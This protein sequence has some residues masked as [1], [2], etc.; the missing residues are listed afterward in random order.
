MAETAST[1]ILTEA[2]G[3]ALIALNKLGSSIPTGADLNTFTAT[4]TNSCNTNTVFQSLVNA[5]KGAAIG[6]LQVETKDNGNVQQTWTNHN[7]V[8]RLQF[9]RTYAGSWSPWKSIQLGA[10]VVSNPYDYGAVGDG[11]ADDTA[12]LNSWLAAAG[13]VK[14]LGKTGVFRVVGGLTSTAADRTILSEGAKIVGDTENIVVLTVTGPNS[15]VRGLS[16]DGQSKVG[17][18]IIVRAPGCTIERNTVVNIGSRTVTSNL[19]VVGIGVTTTGGSLVR[20]N[21]IKNIYALGDGIVPGNGTG[22]SRA[23]AISGAD[24]PPALPATMITVVERNYI[25]GVAGEEGDAIAVGWIPS[26]ANDDI[27]PSARVVVRNN[28]IKNATKRFIKIQG[29]DCTVEKNKLFWDAGA[30]DP[31]FTSHITAY[32]GNNTVITGNETCPLATDRD[33]IHYD[34]GAHATGVVVTDNIIR[35][36]PD[37]TA[38]GVYVTLTDDAVISGNKL[39]G[40]TI[41][42]NNALRGVMSGNVVYGGSVTKPAFDV[43]G[44][45]S[46]V[47][48]DNVDMN[49]ART[50]VSVRNT[51]TN[52]LSDSNL[53]IAA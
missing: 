23:I 48:K 35:C 25:D 45:T 27:F 43:A 29:S 21:I 39:W 47:V 20:D 16:I 17:R 13:N 11:V 18:G 15:T 8:P 4:A 50:A 28:T 1:R 30:A 14:N 24:V 42:M 34:Q 19:T 40:G 36:G 41:L 12:A 44:G 10:E 26:N 7:S 6:F 46:V 32:R 9:V 52:S 38:I 33:H 53:K 3:Q 31:S 51:G 5:P 2:A 22:M 49:A 37:F